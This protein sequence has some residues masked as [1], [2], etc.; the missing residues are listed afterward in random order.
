MVSRSGWF[1]TDRGKIR[2]ALPLRCEELEDRRVLAIFTVTNTLDAGAGSLRQAIIDSNAAAGADIINFAPAV[3]GAT[4]NLTTTMD[5]NFT[6]LLVTDDLTIDAS[7]GA[8]V[9][10]AGND[11]FRIFKIDDGMATDKV[12]EFNNLRIQGGNAN[13]EVV[14]QQ[15][16]HAARWR[17]RQSRGLHASQWH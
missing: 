3:Q 14:D 10:V 8:R 13:I 17:H 5:P 9:T 4:I 1:R 6:G 11:T 16:R 7:A 15:F 12:V 2:T